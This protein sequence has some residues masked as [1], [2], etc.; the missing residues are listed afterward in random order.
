VWMVP[1]GRLD[2]HDRIVWMVVHESWRHG[3]TVFGH[4]AALRCR[5]RGLDRFPEI[6]CS[7][8]ASVQVHDQ[9]NMEEYKS[10]GNKKCLKLPMMLV[11][12]AAGRADHGTCTRESDW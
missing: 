2:L 8:S 6:K 9:T 10:E 1:G 4:D 5:T 3:S 11:V 7:A 12:H